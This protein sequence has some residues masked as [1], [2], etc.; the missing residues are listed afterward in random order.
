MEPKRL[1]GVG[2]GAMNREAVM[3]ACVRATRAACQVGGHARY[4]TVGARTPTIRYLPGES[5]L[6]LVLVLVSGNECLVHLTRPD[7]H[8]AGNRKAKEPL[9]PCNGAS[10]A[11]AIS[12]SNAH[13]AIFA[14]RA[15][16][17]RSREAPYSIWGHFRRPRMPASVQGGPGGRKVADEQPFRAMMVASLVCCHPSAFCLAACLPSQFCHW[18]LPSTADCL[19][20][21]GRPVPVSAAT[22]ER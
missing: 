15:R 11:R 8:L 9:A 21:L 19:L 12:A 17:A 13:C 6:L 3:T 1:R 5:L 2:V 20:R 7:P 22:I 10:T 18:Q 16:D 14:R 4:C